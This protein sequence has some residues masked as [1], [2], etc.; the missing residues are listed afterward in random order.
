MNGGY[1]Y[2][3]R[4]SGLSGPSNKGVESG[5]ADKSNVSTKRNPEII[6]LAKT[7]VCL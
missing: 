5:S 1:C 3:V 2:L 4:K 6:N 7:F